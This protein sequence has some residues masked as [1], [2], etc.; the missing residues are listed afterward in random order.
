M[1]QTFAQE[2]W[3]TYLDERDYNFQVRLTSKIFFD[4]ILFEQFV[5]VYPGNSVK[6]NLGHEEM[7]DTLK[8]VNFLFYF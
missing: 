4:W 7:E 2:N 8:K 6:C 3:T 1:L 5:E